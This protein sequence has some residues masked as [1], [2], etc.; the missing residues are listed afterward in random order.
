MS[1]GRC[2]A[3]LSPLTRSKHTETNLQQRTAR[4]NRKR[5]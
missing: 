2:L 3:S 5:K 1:I 4:E